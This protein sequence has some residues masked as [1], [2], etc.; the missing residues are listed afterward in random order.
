MFFCSQAEFVLRGYV[1]E[2]FFKEGFKILI[3]Y[4]DGV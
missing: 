4:I 3:I 2:L 1:A